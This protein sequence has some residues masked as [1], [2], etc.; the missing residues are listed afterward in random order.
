[1]EVIISKEKRISLQ[2]LTLNAM[3]ELGKIN[4]ERET[5]LENITNLSSFIKKELINQ[6]PFLRLDYLKVF[7]DA[8][9]FK[10]SKTIPDPKKE[11]V[12]TYA[13][14]VSNKLDSANK[15]NQNQIKE[16]MEFCNKMYYASKFY[17]EEFN[18][19]GPCFLTV[20]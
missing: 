13:N 18:T 4:L 6:K 19:H 10:Y 16:L 8:Y 1:M 12:K 14:E 3:E 11:G 17:D 7:S 5:N 15:L 2:D 20:D 9:F